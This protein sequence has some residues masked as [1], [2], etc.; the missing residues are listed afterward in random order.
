M[1]NMNDKTE[2]AILAFVKSNKT[3]KR[4]SVVWYGGSRLSISFQ[5]KDYQRHS[6][7]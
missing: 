6:S 7:L 2:K 4:L 5:L 1:I 3:L